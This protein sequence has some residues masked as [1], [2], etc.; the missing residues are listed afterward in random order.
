MGVPFRVQS[1][2]YFVPETTACARTVSLHRS[3]KILAACKDVRQSAIILRL[4]AGLAPYRKQARLEAKAFVTFVT[5]SMVLGAC[6]SDDNGDDEPSNSNS[7]AVEQPGES[8]PV[9]DF[10]DVPPPAPD[11]VSL[12]LTEGSIDPGGELI[13][14]E[15]FEPLEQ[16]LYVRK[17][18]VYQ[19][20]SG[21]HVVLFRALVDYAPGT[22][23]DCGESGM[24]EMMVVLT[25]V[26]APEFAAAYV[27]FPEGAA[28]KVPS[29]TQL[30]AQAHYINTGLAPLRF[31]D[32]VHLSV[33]DPADV[34]RTVFVYGNGD[35]DFSLP[36]GADV[37][38]GIECD[39][40]FDMSPMIAVP[41]MHYNGTSFYADVGRDGAFTPVIDV[42]VWEDVMR[43]TPPVTNFMNM[44]EGEA[45][46]YRRGDVLRTFCSWR[47]ETS[48]VLEYPYEMCATFGYFFSDDPAAAD[49]L[50]A[51]NRDATR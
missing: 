47:N 34:Q 35:V 25:P 46:V 45:M 44:P 22:I 40:P 18:D 36:P 37:T 5:L 50:C 30:I 29:G 33:M 31:R 41:H 23:R 28:L 9:E 21:H 26:T 12:E 8:D 43:D 38:E 51:G 6:G 1:E 4:C 39:I 11:Q 17:M 10:P 7:P 32:T 42:P 15:Y 24:S 48:N 3:S 14:C 13:L 27:E 2:A 16:D 19:G 49:F 20:A